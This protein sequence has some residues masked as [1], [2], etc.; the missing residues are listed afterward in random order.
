MDQFTIYRSTDT[1]APILNGLS[2][3]LLDVLNKCLVEGYGSMVGAGWTKPLSDVLSTGCFQQP[4]GSGATL[5]LYDQQTLHARLCGYETVSSIASGIPTGS[6]PFP[7]F[8]TY[9]QGIAIFGSGGYL[10]MYKSSTAGTTARAWYVLADSRSVYVFTNADGSTQWWSCMFG[11]IY[12]SRS[13]IIDAYKCAII[14]RISTASVA[15]SVNGM[16]EIFTNT[17]KFIQR[18]AYLN[19]PTAFIT[20]GDYAKAAEQNKL[21]GNVLYPNPTDGKIYLSPVYVTE[22]NFIRGKL[23]GFYHVC[24]PAAAFTNEQMISGSGDYDGKIFMIIATNQGTGAA[25]VYCMETSDTL[26]SN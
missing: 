18:S 3:S 8:G 9:S 23:R 14:A 10:G 24:H 2:G 12:A 25:G 17:G 15:N 4:T 22:D 1:D 16:E 19:R 20:V 13:D 5:F 7:D 6:R 21:S 26:E 11:D